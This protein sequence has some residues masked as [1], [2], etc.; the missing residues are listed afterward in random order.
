MIPTDRFTSVDDTKIPTGELKPVQGTPFD[1]SMPASIGARIDQDDEQL[2]ISGCYNHN[3][4]IN[5]SLTELGL[6]ARV[7]EANTGSA[8]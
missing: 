4:V 2:R 1:F 8:D 7:Y 6:K 5:K 3:W